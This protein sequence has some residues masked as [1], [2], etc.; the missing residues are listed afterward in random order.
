MTVQALGC[1]PNAALN[2]RGCAV[3]LSGASS[4]FVSPVAV[5]LSLSPQMRQNTTLTDAVQCASSGNK[6]CLFASPYIAALNTPLL[7]R[8]KVEILA[9]FDFSKKVLTGWMFALM[10]VGN[11]A[12]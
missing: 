9:V 12:A 10:I 7:H 8:V 3:D 1:P 11:L 4:F 6:Q 5:R 2:T